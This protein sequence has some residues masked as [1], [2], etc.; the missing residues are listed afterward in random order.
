MALFDPLRPKWRHSDPAVRLEAVRRLE[1][2]EVETLVRIA[3]EDDDVAVRRLCVKKLR[4][5]EA[6]VELVGSESDD[7][8]RRLASEKADSLL[9]VQACAE[10]DVDAGGAALKRIVDQRAL[11]DVACE[12]RLEPIRRAA[13]ERVTDGPVL[14]DIARKATEPGVRLD[15]IRRG[16]ALSVLR[17]IALGD[18]DDDVAL[19]AVELLEE[20][21]ALDAVARGAD[22]KAA[23]RRASERLADLGESGLTSKEMRAEQRELVATT[24]R[25][26][27]TLEF[28]TA[29][30][31]LEQAQH[32]WKQI[33]GAADADLD[34][35]FRTA[36]E[37]FDER[38]DRHR[39][40]TSE[41]S[42]APKPASAA[43][44][45]DTVTAPAPPA[46]PTEHP[47]S[48]AAPPSASELEALVA[49]A[50]TL[51][52]MD[53][54]RD[55]SRR[56]T[57]IASRWREMASGEIDAALRAR[58][59]RAEKR[60]EERAQHRARA[61]EKKR[62]DN[63]QHLEALMHR[64]GELEKATRLKGMVKGLRDLRGAM[65]DIGPL[66]SGTSRDELRKKLEAALAS[67]TRR[68]DELRE[69]DEWN[70]WS[71]ESIRDT[72]CQQAEQLAAL[73]DLKNAS[74]GLNELQRR[75][76]A[77]GPAP[78]E[79]A[80]VLWQRFR[81]A[82]STLRK[83]LDQ[84]HAVVDVERKSNYE[85]KL[86]LC[87]KAEALK[88]STDWKRSA[89]AFKALQAEWKATGPVPRKGSD[90]IW[91][92]FRAACDAFFDR[93]K[94]DLS[95]LDTE[96]TGN[97]EKKEALCVRAEELA[98]S[99]DWD[100]VSN[101]LKRLQARW[102]MIGPVPRRTSDAIWNRFRGTCDR[103]FERFARRHE[104]EDDDKLDEFEAVVV[105]IE[106]LVSPH[107]PEKVETPATEVETPAAETPAAETPAAETPAAETPAAET[108][109]AEVEAPAAEVE[110]P[111]AEVETPAAEVEAPAA[112]VEAPAA[113]VDAPAAE[114]EAPA[115]EVEAPAAEVDPAAI[116]TDVL[117]AWAESK[118]M[119][120][121]ARRRDE[122][123]R[124]RLAGAVTTLVGRHPEAFAG[125]ELDPEANA[126]RREELIGR[127]EKLGPT[128]EAEADTTSVE[129]MAA[130]LRTALAANTFRG[131]EDA[132]PW[133]KASDE[134][135]KI[136][137]AWQRSP[138]VPGGRGAELTERYERATETF[139][140]RRKA[141]GSS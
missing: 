69:A 108:P 56:L 99:R 132:D 1:A 35:R 32:R 134:Q 102:K 5:V 116:A 40:L 121:L 43:G 44:L 86:A 38:L 71:N 125:S 63:L 82:T 60:V 95:R 129:A 104:I 17:S 48:P 107:A 124:S 118:R 8:V 75:W 78:H 80:D 59:E 58:F 72:L 109:A 27:G 77:A 139:R 92:R 87:N 140:V 127:L 83:R 114:V 33:G 89:D 29:A 49:D 90:E 76:K 65:K 23:R 61:A 117:A 115:A 64:C 47:E 93:R 101:E 57:R 42:P 74:R 54:V 22:R 81:T 21:A 88:D 16:V 19:A 98:D 26:A 31:D 135:L 18:Q 24:E 20:A 11:A 91:K 52:A 9:V 13:L 136:A 2:D 12:A 68:Y 110:A 10:T 66:P 103:F 111:A 105:R 97:L 133:K 112:E 84:H 138:P 128:K 25:L 106:A 123:L 137:E 50:E 34:A 4:S 130:R 85:R 62:A 120:P 122:E 41:A 96:R 37:R 94:E 119:K 3:R 36:I 73:E 141:A 70:R 55:A 46:A 79:R 45:P 53:D 28:D 100:V 51:A 67:L 7:S 15:A 131:A 126:N 30:H 6:L 39:K 113:E 14:G